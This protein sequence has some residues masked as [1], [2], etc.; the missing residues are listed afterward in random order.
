MEKAR[1]ILKPGK[2]QSIKR[3][4]PWL[5]SGAIQ[6]TSADLKEGEVVDIFS[7]KEEYL[8]SGHFQN[9]SIAVRILTFSNE[10]INREFFKSKIQAALKLRKTAG[11]GENS[12]TNVF[13]LVFGEGDGLA[14]LIVD[15]YDNTAVIQLHSAGMFYSLEDITHALKQVMGSSITHIYNKSSSSIPFKSGVKTEDGYLLEGDEPSG[16]VGENGYSFKVDWVGG[17]K[18]GFYIDQRDNRSLLRQFSEGKKVLNLFSYS[19]GF[20]VYAMG[21]KAMSVD[22][23][24]SSRDAIDLAR[25]NIA[26][27]F[28]E[29]KRHRV[30]AIDAY[31]YLGN[32]KEE[33]D[34]I[35]LDPP[36]FAKH[37]NVLPNA[38]KGYQRL[39]RM[40]MERIKPGGIIF[41]FSCS[42]V[43]SRENFRKSVFA[44]A[45]NT[46]RDIRILHQLSQPADHPVSIYH[47]EGEYLKG[48]VLK[49]D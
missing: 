25:E 7:Q 28:P 42:Q 8:A 23:V 34:L 21:G 48:L 39:N 22:S 2:E 41:T 17:Q 11:L 9:S 36:A 13:R 16:I 33:Y 27:N 15:I 3:F 19:G 24:D 30:F 14:G 47:P 40:A 4:H 29:D 49:V 5:F 20:S 43:V 1:I 32:M 35:I 38:L 45:A 10:S 26:L 46:G 18:T 37:L 12:E 6:K 31:K 44:A